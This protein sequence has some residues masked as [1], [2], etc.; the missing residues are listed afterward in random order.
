MGATN[1][2]KQLADEVE[3]LNQQLEDEEEAKTSLQTKLSQLTLQVGHSPSPPSL[4]PHSLCL[5]SH[6]SSLYFSLVHG[7][8]LNEAKKKVDD[9]Q[10]ELEEVQNAKRKLDQEAKALQE[11][12]EEMKAENAKLARGKKK[13][14]EEV[15]AFGG[16]Y[17]CTC[18]WCVCA[19]YSNLCNQ[20]LVLFIAV[21]PF[22]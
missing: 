2:Q 20:R 7:C 13:V 3:R 18:R 6:P 21:Q 9:D 4:F 22:T 11:R 17:I 10:V 15:G 14:Q 1:K 8:Q 19:I 5:L 12:L 16:V